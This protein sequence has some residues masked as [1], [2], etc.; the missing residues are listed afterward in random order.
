ML[1]LFLFEICPERQKS[2]EKDESQ[3]IKT[4]KERACS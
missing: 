3:R 1:F 2:Q 4:K